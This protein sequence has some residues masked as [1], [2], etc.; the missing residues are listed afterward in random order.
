MLPAQLERRHEAAAE[1]LRA[2]GHDHVVARDACALD[3]ELADDACLVTHDFSA[4]IDARVEA[5]VSAGVDARVVIARIDDSAI[6]HARV[7]RNIAR[8]V[9]VCSATAAAE[10]RHDD[11]K[12]PRGRDCERAAHK[13][14][15]QD[16]A[17]PRASIRAMRVTEA[18]TFVLR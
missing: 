5:R 16:E 2:D 13:A 11:E 6:H 15:I 14:S 4:G 18:A 7:A 12:H 1:A 17:S 8:A 3:A 9:R 10:R